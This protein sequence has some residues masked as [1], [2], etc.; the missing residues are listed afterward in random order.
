MFNVTDITSSDSQSTQRSRQNPRQG[1][2]R[3]EYKLEKTV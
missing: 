2:Q 3:S 1:I